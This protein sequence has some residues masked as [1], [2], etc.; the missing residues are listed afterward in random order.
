MLNC[1]SMEKITVSIH[2]TN[3]KSEQGCK[4]VEA[5]AIVVGWSKVEIG[6]DISQHKNGRE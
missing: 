3:L 5:Y 6:A 1:R 2:Q 4:L